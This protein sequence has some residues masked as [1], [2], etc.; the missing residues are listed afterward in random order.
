MAQ[1]PEFDQGSVTSARL[2]VKVAGVERAVESVDFGGDSSGGLPDQV[3]AVGTGMLSRT[4]S[5]EWGRQPGST[6]RDAWSPFPSAPGDWPPAVGDSVVI[7]ATDGTSVWRR[8]TGRIS[9]NYGSLSDGTLKS[10]ISDNVESRL[11]EP[12]YEYPRSDK[13]GFRRFMTSTVSR[14]LYSAGIW[15]IPP[16]ADPS[17]TLL[18]ATGADSIL[19]PHISNGAVAEDAAGGDNEASLGGSWTWSNDPT[20]R[21][22]ITIVARTNTRGLIG[23][24]DIKATLSNGN[25]IQVV[26]RAGGGSGSDR[27]R[28]DIHTND[29]YIGTYD[30][31]LDE[32][33]TGVV[34]LSVT[35]TNIYLVTA[36]TVSH[37]GSLNIPLSGA[38]TISVGSAITRVR[39]L[40]GAMALSVMRYGDNGAIAR[41]MMDNPAPL[42]RRPAGAGLD[43]RYAPANTRSVNGITVRSLLDSYCDAT[44]SGQWIDEHGRYCIVPR[45]ALINDSVVRTQY[46]AERMVAGA[47]RLSDDSIYAG[48]TVTYETGS[49]RPRYG[50]FSE[51][52]RYKARIETESSPTKID[53]AVGAT[54]IE[55]WYSPAAEVE[56]GPV[57]E[58]VSQITSSTTW[59]NEP[60]GSVTAVTIAGEDSETFGDEASPAVSTSSTVERIGPRTIR[61][62]TSIPAAPAGKSTEMR[63]PESAPRLQFV[64]KNDAMPRLSAGWV[65]DWITETVAGESTGPGWAPVFEHDAGPYVSSGAA[66]RLADELSAEVTSPQAVFESAEMLWNPSRQIGDV[67]R[68][69]M[70][71]PAPGTPAS[72]APARWSAKVIITGISESWSDEGPTQSVTCR[73]IDLVDETSGKTYLDLAEAYRY[74]SS[75]PDGAT[76][77]SVY[78]S[79]PEGA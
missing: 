67:E 9:K 78:D 24:S 41:Q 51:D 74:Y 77:G 64:G 23:G 44:L 28:A 61:V 19:D 27:V 21:G 55:S 76:Y 49:A 47:W 63:L 2:I 26:V 6:S 32:S 11:R 16:P 13:A 54:T 30:I 79:L 18:Y 35:N 62:T 53:S 17:R 71:D 33:G 40:G 45:S 43:M 42:F 46:L 7:D 58:T 56:W 50:H 3:A 38:N 12:V 59:A 39:V 5:I 31:P 29:D 68:W 69:V 66:K 72:S 8:F 1:L 60:E 36:D 73:A 22:T 25:T 37:G 70:S 20:P 4:G 15:L 75:V 52:G 34:S 48:A 10:D 14:A 57:D 65:T